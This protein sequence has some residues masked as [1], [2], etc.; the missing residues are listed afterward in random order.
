MP[1][2]GAPLPGARRAGD[3]HPVFHFRCRGNAAPY[4]ALCHAKSA[5]GR[6]GSCGAPA[7]PVGGLFHTAFQ[8]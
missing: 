3:I 1:A 5:H 7:I 2:S 6:A 4:G 8:A